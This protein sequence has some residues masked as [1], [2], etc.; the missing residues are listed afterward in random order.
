M[1]RHVVI[2]GLKFHTPHPGYLLQHSHF[3]IEIPST[4]FRLFTVTWS[5]LDRNSTHHTQ[6]IY[7]Y[8]VIFWIEIPPATLRIFTAT[9]SYLDR[10]STRHTQVIYCHVVIL[11]RNSTRHT[12]AIYCH[13][14][15]FASKFHTPHSGYL[16]PRGYFWI[17]IPPATLRLFAATW[18]SLHRNSTRH[19]HFTCM[20]NQTYYTCKVFATHFITL[21]VHWQVQ[22]IMSYLCLSVRPL[23]A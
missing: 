21:H 12:Q 5:Y 6:A 8:V 2:S 20:L 14:V 19:T 13:V 18:S 4:T 10:N 3:W 11:D 15:I 16:L 9:W 17:E 22:L 7:C 23:A 1:Y